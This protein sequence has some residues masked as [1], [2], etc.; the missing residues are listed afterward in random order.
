MTMDDFDFIDH[1]GEAEEVANE[2]Q[3]PDNEVGSSLNCA[4]IG[5]GG[6]GGIVVV[7]V[8]LR[9][10]DHAGEGSALHKK[11]VSRLG[12]PLIAGHCSGSA[13]GVATYHRK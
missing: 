11:W 2:D 12:N 1:Y 9:A 5:V 4:I 13:I 6:G 8:G 10:E 7:L 3:L